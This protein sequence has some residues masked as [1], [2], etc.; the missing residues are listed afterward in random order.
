[1]RRAG[2][3]KVVRETAV[4]KGIRKGDGETKVSQALGISVSTLG[5][6]ARDGAVPDSVA[7][8]RLADLIGIP[9][10]PRL[11]ELAGLK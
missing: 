11:R 7:L 2:R 4:R 5:R 6:W 1:M 9:V 3:T 10:D 8:I